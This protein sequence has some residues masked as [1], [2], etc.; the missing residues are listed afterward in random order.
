MSLASVFRGLRNTIITAIDPSG[1]PK[2]LAATTDGRL[3][4]SADIEVG[5]TVELTNT[6]AAKALASRQVNAAGVA[7][8]EPPT[9]ADVQALATQ[10][11]LASVLAALTITPVNSWDVAQDALWRDP[12]NPAGAADA[13]KGVIPGVLAGSEIK[14]YQRPAGKY[15]H[16]LAVKFPANAVAGAAIV[17]DV[18]GLP[19]LP[20][21]FTAN[22]YRSIGVKL[23]DNLSVSVAN[24]TDNAQ[25][26]LE[27]AYPYFAV[28]VRSVT[29][30]PTPGTA[31]VSVVSR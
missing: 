20:A 14:V 26:L 11:T 18:Y 9:Q 21:A 3:K 13:N 28:I 22:D 7:F 27:S 17:I 15:R 19:V 23:V 6:T 1:D 12:N 8:V 4:V 24:T 2:Q 10:T 30:A 5:D 16:E 25:P 31:F 29:M